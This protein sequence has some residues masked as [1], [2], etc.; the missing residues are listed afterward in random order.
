[1]NFLTLIIEFSD[2]DDIICVHILL[3]FLY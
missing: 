3:I 1:L 2:T